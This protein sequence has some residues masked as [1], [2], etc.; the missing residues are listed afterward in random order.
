MNLVSHDKD[1]LETM[2]RLY[3]KRKHQKAWQCNGKNLCAQCESLRDYAFRR[4][5]ACKQDKRVITCK[6]C[7][8]HCYSKSHKQ[9][10]REVM[11][12]SG[13]RLLITH[14]LLVLKHL[15]GGKRVS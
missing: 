12:F 9:A 3:C 1:I 5:D 11:R 15:Q 2:I 7:P 4:I 8:V 10:I 6:D 13:P 14:P